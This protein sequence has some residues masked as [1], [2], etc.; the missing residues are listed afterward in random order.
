MHKNVHLELPCLGPFVQTSER[1]KRKPSKSFQIR[2]GVTEA[3]ALGPGVIRVKH[4]LMRAGDPG[5]SGDFGD[6]RGGIAQ[7]GGFGDASVEFRVDDGP[8][9]E[10]FAHLHL[11]A[12][13]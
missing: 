13:V 2:P 12:R 10:F 8:S 7:C 1:S 5:S 6:D 3:V 9:R 4:V 11:S